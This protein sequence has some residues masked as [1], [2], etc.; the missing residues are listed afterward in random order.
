MKSYAEQQFC[1]Y[2]VE[3]KDTI[4]ENWNRKIIVSQNDPF[5][6][7]ILTNGEQVMSLII[8]LIT[9][10]KQIEDIH[11]I[12]RKIA[13]ERAQTG[14]NIGNFVYNTNLGR[15]ELFEA[16]FKMDVKAFELQ[17]IAS[18]IH[19]CF[20]YLIYYTVL[21]YSEIIGKNLEEKQHF[22]K[23][24]HKERLTI[25][26]QMSA[27]FVH[28][29]R[30]PL[31]SIM[32]FVKLLR[33]DN[34]ELPYLD[35]ISHELDQ[36]NFRISQFLLVSRKEMWD[37]KTDF[38]LNDLFHDTIHFLYPSLVNA[39]VSIEENIE[40]SV[41]FYGHRSEI[42]QVFLNILMNSIDALQTISGKRQII[43][44]VSQAKDDVHILI[45]NNGPRIP[46][47]KLETIFEPFVTTK[48]LG[49]G[50]GLFV[51]KQIVEKHNGSVQC[52][53][54]ED[55]TKFIIVFKKNVLEER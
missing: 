3:N 24:T 13:A 46:A 30:N 20:D 55:W 18:K 40:D 44:D 10:E 17:P 2:L 43:I 7:E 27:S 50:I 51:C 16:M 39:N 12:C 9:E 41:P 21:I 14:E 32:G 54:I 42:R 4:I 5:K 45:Q 38:L 19:L 37:E 6:K 48:Q 52:E 36:L 49:T 26:G 25:L 23:E 33:A 11:A 1:T 15:H 53:S 8:A 29:F 31:T 47:D 28:E 34:P 22:I 35:I